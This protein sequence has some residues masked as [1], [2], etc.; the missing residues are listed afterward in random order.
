M[1]GVH[2]TSRSAVGQYGEDLACRQLQAAGMHILARNWRCQAGELDVIAA[3]G[4]T[5]VVCEV[6]TRRHVHFGAPTEAVTTDKLRRV[7]K[8]AGL[9]LAESEHSDF[10]AVR[11]DVVAVVLPRRG[12]AVIKHLKGVE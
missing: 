7:R 9:W 1:V 5:L 11:V 4:N 6:K 12:A 10:E 2:S 3:D 8:L